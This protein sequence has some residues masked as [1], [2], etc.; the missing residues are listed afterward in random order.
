MFVGV[1]RAMVP[2][3]G[4]VHLLQFTVQ[5]VGSLT[6]KLGTHPADVASLY[7]L[8]RETY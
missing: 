3:A 8:F 6:Q 7:N 2:L 5:N 1:P 4:K